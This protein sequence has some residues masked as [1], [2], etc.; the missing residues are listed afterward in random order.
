MSTG[1]KRARTF[2]RKIVSGDGQKDD[3]DGT[4]R[5]NRIVLAQPTTINLPTCTLNDNLSDRPAFS[6]TQPVVGTTAG[7]PGTAPLLYQTPTG[8]IFMISQP[9]VNPP[10]TTVNRQL[11]PLNLVQR[12]QVV[13]ASTTTQQQNSDSDT[14]DLCSQ[15][16]STCSSNLHPAPDTAIKPHTQ[17]LQVPMILQTPTGQL[18]IISQPAVGGFNFT[19]NSESVGLG[20]V[21]SDQACTTLTKQSI[22]DQENANKE[23]A[24]IVEPPS[25]AGQ[26]Q[27]VS[28]SAELDYDS[29]DAGSWFFSGIKEEI[30]SDDDNQD[31][32]QEDHDMNKQGRFMND[33]VCFSIAKPYECYE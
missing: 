5:Q 24:V 18:F 8:Q 17:G 32:D 31:K 29:D 16:A 11:D 30:V 15:Q 4:S 14:G 25:D 9:I 22:V 28:V 13:S 19:Q 23:S 10:L 26:S 12:N 7:I 20:T 1:S 33:T 3:E 2:R 27:E 6:S 21:S